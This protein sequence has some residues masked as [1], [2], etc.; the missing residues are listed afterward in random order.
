MKL[1]ASSRSRVLDEFGPGRL[2]DRRLQERLLAVVEALSVNPGEGLPVALRDAAALE[3]A[4]RLINNER[5]TFDGIHEEHAARTRQRAVDAR[6][7]LVIHDTTACSFPHAEAEDIGFLSTGKAG[8]YVHTS[9]VTSMEAG[10]ARP[11]GI[12]HS[13]V[14]SRPKRTRGRGRHAGGAATAKQADREFLRWS[15][16]VTACAELL[17][18]VDNV[19]HVMDSEGDSFALL[20]PMVAANQR[21]VVRSCHNRTARAAADEEWLKLDELS[22][23]GDVVFKRTVTLSRRKKTQRPERSAR[24]QPREERSAKLS[25]SATQVTFRG[26]RYATTVKQIVVNVVRVFEAKPP[27]GEQPVEWIL[28]T[29]EPIATQADIERI[30][31]IYRRRWLI[32]E[33]FKALKSGC[34]YTERQFET[35]DALKNL[36]AI[37]LPIAVEILWLRARARATPDAPATEVF[38][39]TQLDVLRALG[40]RPLSKRPTI[41]GAVWALAGLAGHRDSNGDPGWQILATAYQKLLDYEAGWRA[42]RNAM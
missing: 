34:K 18:D 41:S 30:V 16:G 3:G 19:V 29:T 15:R 26:P 27:K 36:L 40:H 35:L 22:R 31:D 39:A 42:A 6:D 28:L 5:V 7:V 23:R 4:Y 33:F 1:P 12:A 14:V 25:V 8:F 13:E 20:A 10:A 32:E 2:P 38:T 24:R 37:F 17:R 9:L 11:L 21:F